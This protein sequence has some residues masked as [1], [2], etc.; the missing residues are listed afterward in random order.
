MTWQLG[1]SL[2]VMLV[3]GLTAAFTVLWWWISHRL[4]E[5]FWSFLPDHCEMPGCTR[6]G[7]RGNENVIDGLLMCDS[8]HVRYRL[9]AAKRRETDDA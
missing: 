4:F 8:C 1:D 5:W 6:A 3:I 9:E 7:V 2:I